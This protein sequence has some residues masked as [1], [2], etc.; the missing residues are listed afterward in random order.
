MSLSSKASNTGPERDPKEMAVIKP[1]HKITLKLS[2]LTIKHKFMICTFFTVTGNG[3]LQSH[4]QFLACR[5]TGELLPI[6]SLELKRACIQL[7][8]SDK[9]VNISCLQTQPFNVTQVLPSGPILLLN[10]SVTGI[11]CH[12][13]KLIV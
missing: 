8:H 11:R 9:S 2:S 1:L 10:L 3:T 4:N 13:T 5:S 7:K 6:W 12:N